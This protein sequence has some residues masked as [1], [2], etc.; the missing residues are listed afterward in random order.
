MSRQ[1]LRTK[2]TIW[3]A[4]LF[5]VAILAFGGLQ[6][7]LATQSAEKILDQALITRAEGAIRGGRPR[8]GP[9]G[10]GGP[11]GGQG[12]QQPPDQVPNGQPNSQPNPNG[13]LG[14]PGGI[15]PR[16]GGPPPE[17]PGSP[18]FFRRPAFIN[19]DGSSG[20]PQQNI[21]PWAPNLVQKTLNGELQR[22]YVTVQETRLRVISLPF[23][24]PDGKFDA[25]QVVQEA[26]GIELAQ[27]AQI[28][29]M[30]STL[31]IVLLIS[32]GLSLVLSRLV[33]VPVAKLTKAAEVLAQNP[34]SKE[35]IE[36]GGDDEM[37][38]LSNSF[39]QMTDQMQLANAQ[40]AESLERQKRFTS[41]A[42]H[43]LRTPL[44][45]IAL[46]AQNGL[47]DNATEEDKL[48]S[49]QIIDRSSAS[50]RRLTDILLSL[51]RIDAGKTSI[52][53][54]PL[55]IASVV[56]E[57]IA[58]AGLD[59]DTRIRV[60]IESNCPKVIA[61]A[62]G[63]RQILTNLLTNAAA[64]TPKDG[65]ILI[66]QTGTSIRVQDSGSGI[67]P[68]HL[69]KLFDRFY[70][71]DTSRTKASGGFG[72]GLAITKALVEAQGAGITVS[73][74]VGVGTTFSIEFSKS[75]QNS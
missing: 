44:T 48:R 57:A 34:S 51:A 1:S 70:R 60:E 17:S 35:R 37:G 45:S 56:P 10:M 47:H 11:P 7:W 59:G 72:L 58:N 67:A 41:D 38:R 33:L 74:S 43:E 52:E 14:N 8:G 29:S 23:A 2:L 12:G 31:P 5:L 55:L 32:F 3:N 69:P 21:G 22:G 19:A 18:F 30:L 40:L 24:R 66:A 73:S 68:E 39:N 42:A 53:L 4:A 71:V 62:D 9:F 36:S 75:D 27:K 26:A 65:F 50:L 61:N 15:V 49:L 54:L 28:L 16:Q 64:A 63:L 46:A 6:V 13:G 25:V 20:E